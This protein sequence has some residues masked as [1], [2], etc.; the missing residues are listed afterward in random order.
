[1]D[2]ARSLFMLSVANNDISYVAPGVFAGA[3]ATLFALDLSSNALESAVRLF[4][5]ALSTCVV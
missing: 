4:V 2:G 5:G 3:G 1:M